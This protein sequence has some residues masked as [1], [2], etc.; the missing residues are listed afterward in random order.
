LTEIHRTSLWGEDVLT[1]GPFA[2]SLGFRYDR[3]G[4][5]TS[6]SVAANPLVPDAVPGG[7]FAEHDA[8]FSWDTVS[9]RVGF[10]W[11]VARNGRSK[12]YGHY[13]RFYD[14]LGTD[15]ASLNNPIQRLAPFNGSAVREFFD[16]NLNGIFDQGENFDPF[17]FVGYPVSDSRFFE[18]AVKVTPDTPPGHVDEFLGGVEFEVARSV[19]LGVRYVHRHATDILDFNDLVLD[20]PDGDRLA[21]AGDYV[22]TGTFN[23][24]RLDGTSVTQTLYGLKSP[25]SYD[26]IQVGRGLRT[27]DYQ[28]AALTF[29]QRL[30]NRW[31]LRG[32]VTFEDWTWNVPTDSF[33]NGNNL[34]GSDDEN[35]APV[36]EPSAAH[37]KSEVFI[38]SR[39]SFDLNGLYQIAPDRPWGF[40]VAG[41]VT[42]RQGYPRPEYV[43]ALVNGVPT[44][45][46]QV[47]AFDEHRYD[48]IA[49]IDARVEKAFSFDRFSL[50]ISAD[51][52]NVANSQT[53]LQTDTNLNSA[54]V[55]DPIELVSPRTFRFGARFRF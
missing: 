36:G 37:N 55:G 9:P 14:T 20:P 18:S 49:I 32:N 42:G 28:G 6:G 31:M 3:Q 50:T 26:G 48:R 2:F 11:D 23:G 1:T 4:G 47:G 30:A 46:V 51:A 24:Q 17:F 5:K 40:D 39:W 43:P 35:G 25:L 19:S 12:L 34:L 41:N 45:N 27:Q 10:T 29:N 44:F 16:V 8:P 21:V 53:S 54:T 38:H 15:L 7:T 33:Q 22:P 13:G 52:F